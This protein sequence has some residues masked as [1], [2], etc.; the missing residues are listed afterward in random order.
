MKRF[1]ASLVV[2]V[3]VLVTGHGP[4]PAVP[5]RRANPLVLAYDR[6]VYLTGDSLTWRTAPY[7][8]YLFDISRRELQV[9]AYPGVTIPQALPWTQAEV[10]A[11]P[12]PPVAVVALGANDTEPLPQLMWWIEAMID[13]FPK[14]ER[15]IWVNYYSLTFD[16]TAKNEVLNFVASRHSNVTVLDWASVISK[17]PEMFL[18]DGVHYTPAGYVLRALTIAR[19]L[20]PV[21]QRLA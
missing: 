3:V 20:P 7:L 6:S 16:D 4:S 12:M 9:K 18:P 1:I 17:H 2:G 5:V 13:T 8:Q 14:T 10:A 21:V 11:G 19:A 15:I